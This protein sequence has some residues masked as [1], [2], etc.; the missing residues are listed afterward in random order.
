MAHVQ[1]KELCVD[2]LKMVFQKK[3]VKDVFTNKLL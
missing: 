1:L 3:E 2:V